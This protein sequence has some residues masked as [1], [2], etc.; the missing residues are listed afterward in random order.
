MRAILL[1]FDQRP[2]SFTLA[3]PD[4]VETTR[5]NYPYATHLFPVPGLD[6]DAVATLTA[7]INLPDSQLE[8]LRLLTPATI[9]RVFGRPVPS[10]D[11]RSTGDSL[12]INT[13]D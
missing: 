4:W 3:P 5:I 7:G 9:E 1:R 11:D 8:A 13:V 2:T 12:T 6:D 10:P